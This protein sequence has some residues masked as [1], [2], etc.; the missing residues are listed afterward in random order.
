M[1]G[2][3]WSELYQMPVDLRKFYYKMTVQKI[4]R[5]NQQIEEQNKQ[6][7]ANNTRIPRKK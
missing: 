2:F 4:E 5:A 6:I 7:K 1:P 3:S